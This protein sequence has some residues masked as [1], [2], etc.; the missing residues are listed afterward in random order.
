MVAQSGKRSHGGEPP[1]WSTTS[2]GDSTET[3]AG[4]L[5]TLGEHVSSCR[6]GAGRLGG[7]QRGLQT[8][9]GV[10][11]SRFVTTLAVV[12]ALIGLLLLVL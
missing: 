5:S 10:V 9:H 12:A 4:D 2:F 11:A 6:A 7:L 8:V 3:Q 1:L